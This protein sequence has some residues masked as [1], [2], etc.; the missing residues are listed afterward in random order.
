MAFCDEMQRLLPREIRE[1]IYEELWSANGGAIAPAHKSFSHLCDLVKEDCY[2]KFGTLEEFMGHKAAPHFIKQSYVGLETAREALEMWYKIVPGG[3]GYHHLRAKSLSEAIRLLT[4]DTFKVDLKPIAV[5]RGLIVED[6]VKDLV[7][8]PAEAQ[9]M[10]DQLLRIVYERNFHLYIRLPQR[11]IRQPLDPHFRTI[12]TRIDS[13]QGTQS[14]HTRSM[15]LSTRQDFEYKVRPQLTYPVSQ[16]GMEGICDRK[17]FQT[18]TT[19]PPG[20]TQGLSCGR[21]SGLRPSTSGR[22]NQQ[23]EQRLRQQSRDGFRGRI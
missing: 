18:A 19:V 13:F 20:Q 23:N 2:C 8:S 1:M 15:V 4:A 10:V 7:A 17:F 3:S 9:A 16:C 21:Q 6:P 22:Y 14:E 12:A 11:N 5:L